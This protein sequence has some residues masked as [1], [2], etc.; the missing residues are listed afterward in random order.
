MYMCAYRLQGLL[1]LGVE[2]AALESDDLGRGIR[3]VGDGRAAV[4]AEPTPHRLAGGPGAFPLLDRAAHGEG[5]LRDDND[6]SLGDVSFSHS[7]AGYYHWNG[8]V[9]K[10]D[11]GD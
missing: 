9:K 1:D 10:L 2:R 3:V 5:G 4:A 7:L 6:E 11:M 8:I